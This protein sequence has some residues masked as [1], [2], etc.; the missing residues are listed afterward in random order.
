V[1]HE[2]GRLFAKAKEAN[3]SI[4]LTSDHGNCEQMF[5]D[6][7]ARL[8]NHTTFEVYGFVMDKRVQKVQKGGLNNIAP[9][10]LKLMGLPIPSEM[11]QP[12]VEF[13]GS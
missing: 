13:S 2:L 12:L 5:D 3:Y 9:T 11:D 6:V 10:V 1:D 4:V 8:T 7:G